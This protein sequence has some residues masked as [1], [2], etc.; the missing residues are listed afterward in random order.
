MIDSDYAVVISTHCVVCV[1]A[2]GE[3]GELY[4]RS[5]LSVKY[6]D[7]DAGPGGGI[8]LAHDVLNMLFDGLFGNL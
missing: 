7:K 2:V 6:L 4:V 5:W 8:S 1:T 3:W